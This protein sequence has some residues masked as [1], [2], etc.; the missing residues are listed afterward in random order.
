MSVN[1]MLLRKLW[2]MGS[3]VPM[4]Y[5]FIYGLRGLRGAQQ[6]AWVRG[7]YMGVKVSF[8]FSIANLH[9]NEFPATV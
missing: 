1:H 9:S 5:V 3:L 4:R 2:Y 6:S 8:K 7:W